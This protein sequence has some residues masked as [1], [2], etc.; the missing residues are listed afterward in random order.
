MKRRKNLYFGFGAAPKASKR[1]RAKS[2]REFQ[3]GV[4][5]KRKVIRRG[6]E[7]EAATLFRQLQRDAKP[8]RARR[9]KM[10]PGD[11]KAWQDMLRSNPKRVFPG[12]LT[13]TEIRLLRKIAKK[14]AAFLKRQGSR[15]RNFIPP[16]LFDDYSVLSA[17][18]QLEGAFKMK[19][20]KSKKRKRN[21]HKGKMPAGL[22]AYWAKKRRAKNKRKNPK[23]RKRA[24]RPRVRRRRRAASLRVKNYR[25]T[26]KPNSR[27]RRR[28]AAPRRA[29]VKVI[30]APRG[31]TGKALR[32]F[33]RM[34]GAKYGAPARI[35][36][37]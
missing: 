11:E 25:R 2:R 36:G 32:A 14:R 20:K 34:Q 13:P 16:I 37:R 17:E 27:R 9:Y 1:E 4:E 35:I 8:S 21:S 22:K 31:M 6:R 28:N 10:T 23:R 15:K 33:A 26:R 29:G 19:K 3:S 12:D 30:K 24:T 18:K 5:R 7:K